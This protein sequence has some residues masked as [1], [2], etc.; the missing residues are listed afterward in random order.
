MREFK[1]ES[2][3]TIEVGENYR[4]ADLWSGNGDEKEIFESG[5]V[6]IGNDE[7]DMPIIAYFE[8]VEED[9]EDI[10]CSFV[11]VTDIV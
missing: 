11:K 3:I 6:W 4:F 10:I 1:M 5:S 9:K 2:G 8:V 7:N